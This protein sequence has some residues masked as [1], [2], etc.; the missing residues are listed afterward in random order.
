MATVQTQG[1][2]IAIGNGASPEV[3]NNIGEVK[4]IQG[5]DG[6]AA[7]IDTT[8]LSSAA[9]EFNMGLPDEGNVSISA[10]YD[11]ADTYQTAVKTARDNQTQTNFKIT[12]ADTSTTEITFAAY[13]MRFSLA[14]DIDNVA[15][16]DMTLRITG[17]I[18]IA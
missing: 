12:C 2:T 14:W 15:M 10:N 18:T 16:L 8:N 4:S 7:E 5:P 13:V 3:F 9:R 1:T 17:A 6:Q 11:P